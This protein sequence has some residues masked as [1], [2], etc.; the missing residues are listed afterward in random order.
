[1]KFIGILLTFILMP[2]LGAQGLYSPLE[3]WN[4]EY[5]Q[6]DY[7]AVYTRIFLDNFPRV[8]GDQRI[9]ASP[10]INIRNIRTNKRYVISQAE[11]MNSVEP[12]QVW[13]IPVGDYVVEK[14]TIND[15]K[16]ATRTWKPPKVPKVSIRYLFLSNMGDIRISPFQSGLKVKFV[17]QKNL[18]KNSL[19]HDSFA[20]VIDAYSTKVQA[21][22]GGEK[23]LRSA[24]D[25]FGSGNEART[26]FSMTRTIS[27]VY[28]VD[29][30]GN[31]STRRVFSNTLSAQDSD[32]RRCYMDELDVMAGLRGT[33][34]F[35][36]QLAPSGGTFSQIKYQGGNLQSPKAVQCLTLTLG[37][38]QFPINQ[39]LAGRVTFVFD[40]K[41]DMGRSH[42]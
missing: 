9:T 21:K 29:S 33:A 27:M 23:T 22:L 17:Q 11:T 40:Y 12:I 18:Y 2:K 38:M 4:G 10:N 20:G 39:R 25:D 14:I 34:D 37:K 15:N 26:A 24:R 6:N 16:G 13:K 31:Q 36:F 3:P 41:E 1:M 7:G 19:G 32:L 42:P 5:L 28:R 30:S 35:Q 8:K